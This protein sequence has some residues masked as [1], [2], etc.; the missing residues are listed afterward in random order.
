MTVQAALGR[1][2]LECHPLNLRCCRSPR[3]PHIVAA[4]LPIVAYDPQE[5]TMLAEQQVHRQQTLPLEGSE[6][7]STEP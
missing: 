6:R 3:G 5:P 4:A 7:I 1:G 2:P